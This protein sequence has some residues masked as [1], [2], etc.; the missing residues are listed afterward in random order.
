MKNGNQG[1]QCC[2]LSVKPSAKNTF[3]S[4][5]VC[6]ESTECEEGIQ[7]FSSQKSGEGNW[8]VMQVFQSRADFDKNACEL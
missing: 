4:Y 2:G 6:D 5:D 3:D 8:R 1:S 7:L